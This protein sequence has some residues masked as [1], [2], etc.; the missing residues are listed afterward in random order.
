MWSNSDASVT[1]LPQKEAEERLLAT[2]VSNQ[3][4]DLHRT[5]ELNGAI[6]GA[7]S[8][9]DVEEVKGY[10]KPLERTLVLE[11]DD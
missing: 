3:S 8:K 9:L 10:M 6:V 5:K 11:I 2:L 7:T 1:S 4:P